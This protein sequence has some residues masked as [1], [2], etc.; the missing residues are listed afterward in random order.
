MRVRFNINWIIL[1]VALMAGCTSAPDSEP[2][3]LVLSTSTGTPISTAASATVTPTAGMIM[4]PEPTLETVPTTGTQNSSPPAATLTPTSTEGVRIPT[5]ALPQITD[6][7]FRLNELIFDHI[8]TTTCSLPCWAG[9]NTGEAGLSDLAELFNSM[10]HFP[11]DL[12]PAQINGLSDLAL[13]ALGL[14]SIPEIYPVG[15]EWDLAELGLIDVI[16]WLDQDTDLL[17]AVS[18]HWHMSDPELF[19]VEFTAEDLIVALGS[20]DQMLVRVNRT[21]LNTLSQ[22]NFLM[23]YSEGVT[24][25]AD[26][27]I[28]IT[29]TTNGDLVEFCLDS[30]GSKNGDLLL[31]E[32]LDPDLVELTA[33]QDR[34][35]GADIDYWQLT[36]VEEVFDLSPDEITELIQSGESVCLQTKVE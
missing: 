6:H 25:Y 8:G 16:G 17:H 24:F 19:K 26:Y 15:N 7:S 23:A 35:F 1:L 10:F 3:V 22:V 11:P 29:S 9:L 12:N 32:P 34:V 20:P 28:P 13:I 30:S 18:F 36:P 21:S 2:T 14:D 33:L 5:P 4:T 27:K 31:S